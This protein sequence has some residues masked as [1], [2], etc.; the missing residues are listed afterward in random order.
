MHAWCELPD[1]S[2]QYPENEG[3]ACLGKCPEESILLTTFLLLQA[4][5]EIHVQTLQTI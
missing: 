5:L 4:V 2:E 1:R 3:V